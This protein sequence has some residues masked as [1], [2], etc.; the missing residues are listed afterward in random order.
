MKT[1]VLQCVRCARVCAATTTSRL[2]SLSFNLQRIRAHTTLVIFLL[3][4]FPKAPDLFSRRLPRGSSRRFPFL[5]LLFSES[6][7]AA[8][9]ASCRKPKIFFLVSTSHPSATDS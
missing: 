5:S 4:F 7:Y 1:F 9:F 8:E 3:F 2:F 6:H